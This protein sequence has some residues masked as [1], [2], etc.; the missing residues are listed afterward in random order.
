MTTPVSDPRNDR[1]R[2]EWNWL[3]T[4]REPLAFV[5]LVNEMVLYLSGHAQDRLN[6][7]VGQSATV[8][9]IGQESVPER[10]QVFTPRGDWHVVTSDGNDVVI[11]F[12]E[13]PGTYRLKTNKPD[14]PA[15]GFSVNL[16][17]EQSRLQRIAASEL[18]EFLG[19]D[20]YVLARNHHDMDREIGQARVGR[21]FFPHLIVVVA[22]LLGLEHL[23][24]NR[25]YERRS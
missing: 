18:D 4:G 21:E 8:T 17:K 6:Y 14:Q 20:R 9:G 11:R 24:A 19:H 15:R 22:V 3:P 23:L 13:T 16:P 7:Q 2:P 10:F 5:M 1:D 12:T 25:F